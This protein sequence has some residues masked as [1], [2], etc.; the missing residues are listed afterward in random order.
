VP[1]RWVRI[2]ID[3]IL[4]GVPF[5]FSNFHWKVYREVV[6]IHG[7][8]SFGFTVAYIG[9]VSWELSTLSVLCLELIDIRMA[10]SRNG[11]D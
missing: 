6:S 11:D 10:L 4:S 2:L 7:F 1:N 9:K 3:G 8:P 5:N